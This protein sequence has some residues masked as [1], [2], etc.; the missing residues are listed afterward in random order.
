MKRNADGKLVS[1]ASEEK[2]SEAVRLYETTTENLK[3]IAKQLGLTYNSVG[4]YIRRNYPDIIRRHE[5]L[6]KQE[7]SK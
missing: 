4:G 1:R 3:S 6:V 2:Y 5:E 7:N